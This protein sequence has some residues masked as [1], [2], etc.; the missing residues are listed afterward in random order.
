MTDKN[1]I[2]EGLLKAVIE[3][4]VQGVVD[5][6]EQSIAAGLTPL[7]SIEG[8][9]TP[10]IT[11]VGD[12]FGRGEMFLP[13]MVASAE[14]MEAAMGV[15]EPH[16][17]GDEAKKKGK[18][19]VGTVKGDIH[20]IGKNIVIA[21]LKVNGWEVVDLGRD[22]PSADFVDKAIDLK[23]DV[24]GISGL[25][26]TSL[27]MMRDI[28]QMMVEDEVR[29]EIKVIIGGGPTSQDY[30]D[31]IGADGYGDTAYNAIQLCDKILGK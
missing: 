13:E 22:V 4:D 12:A 27:P 21:L 23:A 26:T 8:G 1:R 28:I 16:F 30:A 10:G 6:A 17:K 19:L 24:V 14:A 3:G 29:E 31:E 15:L 7:E 18:V 5:L 20:D 9:L 11:E 2:L 25:L